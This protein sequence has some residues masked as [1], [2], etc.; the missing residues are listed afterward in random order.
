MTT[1]SKK[2]PT[3]VFWFLIVLSIIIG[4]LF[5]YPLK[6]L[7][8]FQF[9]VFFSGVP[10]LIFVTGAFGLLWPKIKPAGDE[11]YIY[12]SL[13]IGVLFFIL[14]FIHVW[15]ILPLICPNFSELLE[16]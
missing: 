2:T 8:G 12:H 10:F 7:F 15:I 1:T 4:Y 11:I 3:S 16:F 13:M 9:L 5:F 6:H 14:F